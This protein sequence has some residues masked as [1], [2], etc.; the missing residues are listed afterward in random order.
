MCNCE[1]EEERE[2]RGDDFSH[3]S[4][5]KELVDSLQGAGHTHTMNWQHSLCNFRKSFQRIRKQAKKLKRLLDLFQANYF[6]V[7]FFFLALTWWFCSEG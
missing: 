2:G 6:I 3:V 1:T 5:S 4:Y 7:F